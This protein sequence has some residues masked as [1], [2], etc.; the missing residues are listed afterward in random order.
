MPTK[1]KFR[2]LTRVL[3]TVLLRHNTN[4]LTI[5][6]HWLCLAHVRTACTTRTYVSVQYPVLQ[7]YLRHTDRDAVD[8]PYRL[9]VNP[10]SWYRTREL[11]TVIIHHIN[12]PLLPGCRFLTRDLGT[13]VPTT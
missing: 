6:F 13:V 1:Y 8:D 2:Y 9:L 5:L 4:P 12:V 3:G 7:Y 11:G 10:G